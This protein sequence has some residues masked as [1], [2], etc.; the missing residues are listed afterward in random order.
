MILGVIGSDNG[1][2]LHWQ[3][4]IIW[5][6]VGMLYWC[7]Y[8]SFSLNELTEWYICIV[9]GCITRAIIS[10]GLINEI[11]I[12]MLEMEAYVRN[13]GITHHTS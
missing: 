1:L 8:A 3:Q 12:N 6:Y 4:A 2:A 13:P 10:N 7:I 5:T 9:I 11:M